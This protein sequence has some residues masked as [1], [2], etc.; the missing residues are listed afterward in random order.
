MLLQLFATF[1]T[2]TR[3]ARTVSAAPGPQ[4]PDT[5]RAPAA[6]EWATRSVSPREARPLSAA[7]N[8]YSKNRRAGETRAAPNTQVKRRSTLSYDRPQLGRRVSEKR[9]RMP[10]NRRAFGRRPGSSTSSRDASGKPGD[11][12][13]SVAPSVTASALGLELD[14]FSQTRNVGPR[15]FGR[16]SED[17][18]DPRELVDGAVLTPE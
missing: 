1:T 14:V 17:R 10:K 12:L 6:D 9:R 13:P 11:S 7:R 15:L 5:R 16:H 18:K 8:G 3:Y 2:A 4:A